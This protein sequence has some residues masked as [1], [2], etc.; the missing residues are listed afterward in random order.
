M[1]FFCFKFTVFI[2]NEF[3]D[4]LP[5]HQFKRQNSEWHEVYINLDTNNNLC[6]MLS[7]N[8]NVFTK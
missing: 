6:F 7:K 3:L 8:E 1:I 5:I 4:S 2:G